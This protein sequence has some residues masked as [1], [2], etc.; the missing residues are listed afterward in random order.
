[1]FSEKIKEVRMHMALEDL[2]DRGKN[3]RKKI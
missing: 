1:M 3:E 2:W